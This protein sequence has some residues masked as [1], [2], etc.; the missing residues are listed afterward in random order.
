[1]WRTETSASGGKRRARLAP[2]AGG[3]WTRPPPWRKGR[4]RSRR[5]S[6]AQTARLQRDNQ[7][8][9]EQPKDQ[10]HPPPPAPPALWRSPMIF[11]PC[12]M[13]ISSTTAPN[14]SMALTV[15][16]KKKKKSQS[17]SPRQAWEHWEDGPD[18]SR[19]TRSPLCA[20]C[21]CTLPCS[22]RPVLKPAFLPSTNGPVT[23][24]TRESAHWDACDAT[25]WLSWR[26]LLRVTRHYRGGFSGLSANSSTGSQHSGGSRQRFILPHDAQEGVSSFCQSDISHDRFSPFISSCAKQH[27]SKYNTLIVTKRGEE[28]I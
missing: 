15:C 20:S 2:D 13:S 25:F 26:V 6:S 1:M 19:R 18:M 16:K 4:W 27:K 10:N 5:L 21:G 7:S 12:R 17:T 28:D 11:L 24:A 23:K 3:T 22:V 9:G 14:C 8:V